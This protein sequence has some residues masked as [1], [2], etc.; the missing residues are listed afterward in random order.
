MKGCDAHMR[1]FPNDTEVGCEEEGEHDTHKGVL[2]NYAYQGSETILTWYEQD[3]RT[4]HGEW[5]GPCD[6]AG[7]ILPLGHYGRHAT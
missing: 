1:P 4:Y 3:R 6:E 7:C 5:P 2:R